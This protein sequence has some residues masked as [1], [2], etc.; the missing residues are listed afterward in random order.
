MELVS[1]SLPEER[2]EF[3]RKTY[4]HLA[5]AVAT[6]ILV[7][8]IFFQT[9]IAP[10]LATMFLG[11]RM[12]WLGMLGGFALLGWLSR[13]FASKADDTNAQYMGLGLYILGESIIFAPLLYLAVFYSD[14][15]VLPSAAI[16]TGVLF[17]GLTFTALTTKK[18]FTFLGGALRISGFIALGA[19]IYSLIFGVTLGFFFS[20]AM[21]VF[22]SCAILYD[23]SKV[24]KHYSSDQY[25]AASLELFAS[26]AL[27]FW[28]VLRLFMSRRR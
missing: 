1:Q 19:I 27:L 6:F 25:V 28:Y 23:T 24:L 11:S 8:I 14:P 22:A 16:F 12:G 17:A 5:G 4:L 2:A 9:G 18:D 10:F 13:S 26:V 21:I 20:L 7:E 15:T 3:I